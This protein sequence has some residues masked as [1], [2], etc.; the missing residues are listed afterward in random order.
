[1]QTK[2]I[3]STAVMMLQEEGKLLITDPISRYL[4]EF[5]NTTVAQPRD[6]GGYDVVA[7]RRPITIRHLLTHTSGF[8]YGE[9]VAADVW[10]KAGIQGWY[11]ANRD[12]PIAATI[13]RL[14]ALPA[15]AQP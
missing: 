2:A 5:E 1:S 15:D 8:S 14:A 10:E 6:G 13:E 12:E 11:F 4:P 7:A 3:V 9:G